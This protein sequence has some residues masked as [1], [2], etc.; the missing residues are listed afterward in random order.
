MIPEIISILKPQPKEVKFSMHPDD[1]TEATLD[2]IEELKSMYPK[3]LEC[4]ATFEYTPAV[5]T[6][7]I[8][9]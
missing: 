6:M 1:I 2:A 4:N 9:D 5:L 7:K 3:L 8:Y